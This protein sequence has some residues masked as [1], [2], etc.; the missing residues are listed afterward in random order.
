M[1]N[2]KFDEKESVAEHLTAALQDS[3]PGVF[4]AAV[5]DVA[6]ARGMAQV[7]KN[8]ALQA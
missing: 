3:D 7:A 5:R 2:D 6:R 8:V 4:L 1:K